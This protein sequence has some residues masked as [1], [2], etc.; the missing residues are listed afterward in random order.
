MSD[1]SK[2]MTEILA[3]L[4]RKDWAGVRVLLRDVP[5]PDVADVLLALGK[6]ERVLLFRLLPR[7]LASD[8]FSYLEPFKKDELLKDLS[9]EEAR[10]LLAD[11]YPDDLAE[12]LEEMPGMATQRLLN[13]LDPVDRKDAL[14]LLG[15]PEKSVGRLMTP[16]Y[17]AVRPEWTVAQA[18]DHIRERGRDS[19]TIHVIHVVDARW[20]LLDTLSLRRFILAGPD[21]TVERIMDRSF[22]SITASEDRQEAVRL[23]QHYDLVTLPVV[24]SGGVLLGIVTVDDVLDVAQKEATEDIQLSAAVS[25]LKISYRDS[26]LWT[27]FSRRVG[28]LAALVLVNMASGGVIAYHEDLLT[29]S[30]A[31]TF[32]IPL[33][34]ATGGNAGSQSATLMVRAMATGEVKP[35][36]YTWAVGRELVVGL[37]LGLAL[38]LL[39]WMLGFYRGGVQMA[40]VLFL[41]M[42]SIVVVTNIIGAGLPFILYR[43]GMDPAVASSPLVTSVADVV[44]LIIYFFIAS[45]LMGIPG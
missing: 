16:Y 21:D 2:V 8:A 9:D 32:F 42:A 1:N 23:I 39:S 18:L 29:S 35:A 33:L 40:L 44:G 12:F 3:L 36:Q 38:G 4:G 15:Y 34:I 28:W 41:A 30:I 13:L 19:E 14:H 20:R 31:L 24:D 27:L 26:G 37:I 5:P 43:L 10:E 7:S 22:V 6:Q 25:P 11:L 17:V 45:N